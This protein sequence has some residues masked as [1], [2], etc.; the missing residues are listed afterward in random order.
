MREGT[1]SKIDLDENEINEDVIKII[2]YFKKNREEIT[3]MIKPFLKE[4][5][6]W[7]RLLAIDRAIIC[8]A[9]CESKILKTDKKVI[10]DQAII[11]SKNFSDENSYK[12]IN[13]ILDKVL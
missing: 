1:N 9:I 5:W 4:N 12:F 2:N 10:I 6:T 7:N 13:S 8:N 11:T 3:N